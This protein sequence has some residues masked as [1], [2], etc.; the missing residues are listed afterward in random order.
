MDGGKNR[1]GIGIELELGPR[2]ADFADNLADNLLKFDV[3]A[4][5]NFTPNKHET[6][7]TERFACYTRIRILSENR[8]KDGIRNLVA[9][10]VRMAFGNGF[11]SEQIRHGGI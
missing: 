1:A 7:G 8:I 6:G 10:F 5:G 4:G 11:R 9:N 2:V 3:G